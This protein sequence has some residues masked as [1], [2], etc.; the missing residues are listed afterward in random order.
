[1]KPVNLSVSANV[2]S[3][4]NR[5]RTVLI[6]DDCLEERETIK[7][8]L[9][10]NSQFCC[11]I[12]E[13]E[14]GKEG[15][16]QCQRC[17]PDVVLLDYR[18]PDLNG[19]EVLEQL[20]QQAGVHC[21]PVIMVTGRG[22]ESIAVQAMKAGVADYLIKRRLAA[23]DLRSAIDDAIEKSYLRDRS[24]L[25]E[26]ERRQQIERERI[27]VQI[28]RNVHR[29]L[30][31]DEIFNNTVQQVRQFLE[32]DRVIIFR[33]DPGW[34][35]GTIVNESVGS[36]WTPILSATLRDPCFGKLKQGLSYAERYR[37]G[38]TRAIA[39]I[40]TAGLEDCHIELLA[41]FQIRANL[42]V[43]ILQ[44][45]HL[46][47]L[48][49]AQHCSSV[50]QWQP[51][52]IDLLEQLATQVGIAIQQS[53]LYQ[54]AQ[55]ELAERRRTEVILAQQERRYRYIFE[56]AGASIWE[57]DFSAVKAAIE[58]L[59]ATGVGDFRAYFASHPEFVEQ[60]IDMV[61][62]VDVN[63]TSIQMF[64]AQNKAQLLSSL[65]QIFLPETTEI[66]IEE[67]VAIA[68]AQTSLAGETVLHTLEGKRLNV[69]LTVT[70][71]PTG[72]SYDRVIVTLVDIS[73]RK[74]AELQL[75][76][77]AR[78]LIQLNANLRQT[79]ALLTQRN[80]ELDRFAYAVSHDLKA[81]L[82]AIANLSTWIAEDLAGQLSPDN[83]RQ[84]ELL[85]QRV[86]R[87]DAMIDGLLS[88]ARVGRTQIASEMVDLGELL[89]EIIDSLA[90][91]ST[92]RIEVQSP[93][94]TMI[95][96]RLLLFQVFSNLISN[97]I[98]HHDR[99]DGRIT[100]SASEREDDCEF[101]VA[102]DGPGIASEHHQRIF[103]IFQVLKARDSKENTGIGLSIVKKIV[104]TEG[105]AIGLE[106]QL[107]DGTT[108]R[109]TLPKRQSDR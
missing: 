82:R 39:D 8:Y 38:R 21:P 83:Q 93:M 69:L 14:S 6:I 55:N 104:E 78:E 30:D 95:A 108:F 32:T 74:R 34:N 73:D 25:S 41:Q 56:T 27:I 57:E 15:L 31:L 2:D 71:P 18:L 28:A 24:R 62:L 65:S 99:T 96:K 33:F 3:S 10:Q 1:M 67:L 84:M 79:T 45:G 36:Q 88:Y 9:L 40:Y 97:A 86:Y 4:F 68:T 44:E 103:E 58:R 22:D 91:P 12:V 102:D 109:F 101:T 98:K 7:E 77:K 92:F 81:P 89:A 51:S 13:A 75:Q 47:G 52:D 19:L 87:L 16:V 106:S 60:A 85:Q 23:E 37:Q 107:G 90:P 64:E 48:L 17:Y 53:E 94:P 43:P 11:T 61:R 72:E 26:T 29:L 66:F 63:E 46:W 54:Q 49:I 100:I 50:R 59:K 76:Q 20:H 80:Q 42:V 35:S 105:G 5:H 70:F